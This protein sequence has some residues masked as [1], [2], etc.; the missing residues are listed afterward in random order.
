MTDQDLR[1]RASIE[2]ADEAAGKLERIEGA[3]DKVTGATV[4]AKPAAEPKPAPEQVAAP[5]SNLK[6][7]RDLLA[8]EAITPDDFNKAAMLTGADDD[9]EVQQLKKSGQFRAGIERMAE[10]GGE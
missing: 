8:K 3:H 9:P 6:L 5:E 7:I 1:M 10:L 2:G 4:K